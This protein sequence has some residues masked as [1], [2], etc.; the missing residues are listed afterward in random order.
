MRSQV[1][2]HNGSDRSRGDHDNHHEQLQR[3]ASGRPSAPFPRRRR[4]PPSGPW[5][6]RRRG[7]SPAP[8][9][10]PPSGRHPRGDAAAELRLTGTL[11]VMPV[12][13]TGLSPIMVG[14]AAEL[15]R[16][17]R[18]FPLGA[19]P[20]LALI[21]GEAGVGKTR[22]VQELLGTVPAGT[23]ILTGRAQE[24]GMG[25]PFE[26]LLEAV[27]P[28][29]RD[30]TEVPAPLTPRSEPVRLLLGPVVPAFAS[31]PER[32]Y[33][34]EELLRAG[35]DLVRHVAAAGPAVLVFEDLHWADAES[36]TLFGR[37][38]TTPELSIRLVGTYRPEDLGR[39]DPLAQVLVGLERQR[40]TVHVPVDRLD[41]PGVRDLLGAVFD[42]PI[43]WPVVDA[44]YERTG[45]NPF[46]LEELVVTACCA[47]PETLTTL[48][49]PWN[50]T[51]AVLRHLDGLGPEVL[52]ILDAASV[53]GQRIP[54]DL[55]AAVTGTGEDELIVALRA[56][57][58]GGLL[59]EDEPDV[60]S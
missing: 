44:M 49:L 1:L 36:V 45:G 3:T 38:A 42:C 27:E 20:E 59:V 24:G 43:T 58:A 11:G 48:P 37:L 7:C 16:L 6:R 53:L 21:G 13:R 40:R 14:R 54:F 8:S 46:F 33:G 4:Q 23:P 35:V 39:R 19:D 22:L 18:L 31:R 50:L 29:V 57:V 51:E 47:E 56:L 2:H 15:D 12:G 32:D 25:R 41:R 9:R 5:R 60:F 26:L 34:P 17:A 52:R 55:L 28:L 10:A 30:W